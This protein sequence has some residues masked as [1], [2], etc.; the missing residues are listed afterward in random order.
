[1]SL[2]HSGD[3]TVCQSL[4]THTGLICEKKP[5]LV[6]NFFRGV[7]RGP[8]LSQMSDMFL[9]GT[10][11]PPHLPSSVVLLPSQLSLFQEVAPPRVLWWV[12]FQN[13]ALPLRFQC[14]PMFLSHSLL[15]FLSSRTEWESRLLIIPVTRDN[16]SWL[17]NCTLLCGGLVY[18][19]LKNG[20]SAQ[21]CN[22]ETQLCIQSTSFS[23]LWKPGICSQQEGDKTALEVQRDQVCDVW[24]NLFSLDSLSD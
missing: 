5:W 13:T 11:A 21:L 12:C 8:P 1:M 15:V 2:C 23:M 18:R 22:K 9:W 24:K 4:L 3:S 19:S 17:K 16:C 20:K 6:L 10:S 14:G 7:P